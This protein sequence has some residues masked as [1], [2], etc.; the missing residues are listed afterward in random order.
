M[1]DST[2]QIVDSPP[3]RAIMKQYM[4]IVPSATASWTFFMIVKCCYG[5]AIN[6]ESFN[7]N[8]QSMR[9]LMCS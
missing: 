5:H 4:W 1:M 9:V 6:T 7:S 3:D 8:H 2:A